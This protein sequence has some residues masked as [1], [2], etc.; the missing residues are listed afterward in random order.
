ME[1]KLPEIG[2]GVQE[3]ELIKWLVKEGDSVAEELF[4]TS[5]RANTECA[6][7]WADRGC[8]ARLQALRIS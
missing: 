5:R 6:E 4:Q 8:P 1:F 7:S 2:E 3:G